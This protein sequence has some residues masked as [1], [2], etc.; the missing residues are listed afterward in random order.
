MD[1]T[2]LVVELKQAAVEAFSSEDQLTVVVEV[3]FV[4]EHLQVLALILLV[5][6]WMTI[7]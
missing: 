3:D 6:K 4:L 2:S 7:E 5:Q 1:K